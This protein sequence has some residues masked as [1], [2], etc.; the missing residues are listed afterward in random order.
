MS[1]P[2]S[3][4]VV[5]DL[6][7]KNRTGEPDLSYELTKASVSPSRI[8]GRD[9]RGFPIEDTLPTVYWRP[10]LM[11]DG[12]INKVPLRTGA[13]FS[14]TAEAVAYETETVYDLIVA[15]A[16]P[17]DCC[18]HSTKY[19]HLTGGLPFVPGG[20]DCG[21]SSKESGCE[22]LQRVGADRRATV[23]AN[24]NAE[25]EKLANAEAV[26]YA[27]MSQSIVDGVGRAIAANM[28]QGPAGAA[29]R[30]SKLRDGHEG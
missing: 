1:T 22:H 25:A 12:C 20:V 24:Y 19:Q 28:P 3:P 15:G 21:G 2:Q 13:V 16:I 10:F 14:M 11:P 29:D 18:P 4:F 6:T 23:L 26:K 5:K 8:I 9:G 17:A 7:P 27:N 30:K